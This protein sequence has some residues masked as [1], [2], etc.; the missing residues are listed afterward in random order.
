MTT[1]SADYA[2]L[3]KGG[4]LLG[5]AFLLGGAAGEILGHS[6][7]GSLPAWEN[8]LFTD[9]EILGILLGLLSPFVFGI[10]APLLD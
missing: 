8:T 3:A 9:M 6:L 2:R 7:Y 4:F 5:A 10:A 1:T